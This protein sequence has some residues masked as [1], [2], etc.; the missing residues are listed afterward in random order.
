MDYFKDLT[1]ADMLDSDLRERL[2]EMSVA[3]GQRRDD[4]VRYLDT[5]SH[6]AAE[7]IKTA[8]RIAMS[9]PEQ[10]HF[11]TIAV[12]VKLLGSTGQRMFQI[13]REEARSHGN[14]GIHP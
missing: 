1:G 4:V 9:R 5:A 8:F 14:E 12:L 13:M 2:I 11:F 10:D 6:A 3:G 7:A